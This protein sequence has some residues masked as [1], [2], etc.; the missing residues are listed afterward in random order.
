MVIINKIYLTKKGVKFVTPVDNE[1]FWRDAIKAN[2]EAAA[3]AGANL[4]HPIGASYYGAKTGPFFYLHEQELREQE[5]RDE[6][7]K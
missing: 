6:L 4:T 2:E 5:L 3:H 7:Y 1:Q